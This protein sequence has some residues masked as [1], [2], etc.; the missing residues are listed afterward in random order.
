MCNHVSRGSGFE[1]FDNGNVQDRVPCFTATVSYSGSG[2]HLLLSR[3]QVA[4]FRSDTYQHRH[5]RFYR[6]IE[7]VQL[8]Y[9][10]SHRQYRIES[11]KSKQGFFEKN[12][13]GIPF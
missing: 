4:L 3:L 13:F 8:F 11:T 12:R 5:H 9:I 7:S 6:H 10:L 2:F 1:S